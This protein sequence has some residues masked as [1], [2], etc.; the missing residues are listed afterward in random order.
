MSLMPLCIIIIDVH[1]PD[2][3]LL[4]NLLPVAGRLVTLK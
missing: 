4:V 2:F 3:I 1:D